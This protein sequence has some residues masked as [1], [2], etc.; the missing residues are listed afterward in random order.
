MDASAKPDYLPLVGSVSNDNWIKIYSLHERSVF[1]SH[2]VANFNLSSVDCVQI[3][4]RNDD[5]GENDV[6][7]AAA[8]SGGG[9]GGDELN[10]SSYESN[11]SGGQR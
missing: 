11:S 4:K 8:A 3:W 10:G 6:D 1:R 2:N 7:Q 5:D 9:G